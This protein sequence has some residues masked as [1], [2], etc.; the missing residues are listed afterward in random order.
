MN[1]SVS[2]RHAAL[3]AGG[4]AGLLM[5]LGASAQ[6]Q[7]VQPRSI[8]VFSGVGFD[9]AADPGDRPGRWLR[10][11]P[12]LGADGKLY[13]ATEGNSFVPLT[14]W[15]SIAADGS[16]FVGQKPDTVVASV[17][18]AMVATGSGEANR[19]YGVNSTVAF[20]A[21]PGQLP[22]ALA[23]VSPDGD[24]VTT[25]N[26]V[27]VLAAAPNGDVFFAARASNSPRIWRHLSAG[28]F[29]LIANFGRAEYVTYVKNALG[30]EVLDTYLKGENTIAMVW[31]ETDQALYGVTTDSTFKGKSGL[32]ATVPGDLPVGTIYRIKA[33]AFR[34][35]GSSEIE[36]LHTLGAS[37]DGGAKT[38]SYRKPALLEVGE[39]LYGTTTAAVASGDAREFQ[40]GRVW[41]MRKDCV[42]SAEKNCLE[43]VYRFDAAGVVASTHGGTVPLGPL[44][45]AA[46]GN[47]YGTTLRGGKGATSEK[48]GQGTLFRLSNP[49]AANAADVAFTQVHVFDAASTGS[50][51]N[52]LALGPKANGKQ[53]I[54]GTTEFG[55]NAGDVYSAEKGSAS[56]MGTVFAF[57]VALPAASITSFKASA[58]QVADGSKVTLS[59]ASSGAAVCAAGGDWD[60]AQQTDGNVEVGPLAYRADGYRYTLVCTSA[61]GVASVESAVSVAVTAPVTEP[62]PKPEQS[63]SNDGGSGGGGSLPWSAALLFAVAGGMRLMRRQR[64]RA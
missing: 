52:G 34:A 32:A 44:V 10:T 29:E 39:W 6:E 25:G 7:A 12:T 35:D 20:R 4:A 56:G 19:L 15:Y 64:V 60:G 46:D 16:Q 51:P 9:D 40:D 3:V 57:E 42:S 58:T 61:D 23:K 14:R 37:R 17:P 49:T 5:A 55:G 38:A 63:A 21:V 62:E 1:Y 59:W 28:G 2:L 45:Y 13:G 24:A 22:T 54:V 48:N 53:T 50:T 36:V 8:V 30:R 11:V 43:I 33:G 31:S 41:R 47:V 18:V 26:F 27:D